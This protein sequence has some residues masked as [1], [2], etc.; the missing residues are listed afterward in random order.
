MPLDEGDLQ[1][2]QDLIVKP[3]TIQIEQLKEQLK[4]QTE[5][6]KLSLEQAG[7]TGKKEPN[8]ADPAD[9]SKARI[10][11]LERSQRLTEARA[12]MPAN[13]HPERVGTALELLEARGR[14]LSRDGKNYIQ[15]ERNGQLVD[16][17]LR[18][19]LAEWAG[20]KDADPFVQAPPGGSGARPGAN[21]GA[22]SP[23]K[24]QK[25]SVEDVLGAALGQVVNQ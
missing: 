17:P 20:T 13:I 1:K 23:V 18:E 3:F 12:S 14:I 15:I 19:G 21:P 8:A 22:G 10:A 6:A 16:M 5:Q 11:Q 9:E 25:V 4:T 7:K 24:G 2:I